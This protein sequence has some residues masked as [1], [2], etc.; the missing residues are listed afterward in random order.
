M[1]RTYG[2]SDFTA[3]NCSTNVSCLWHGFVPI[4]GNVELALAPEEQNIYRREKAVDEF[5]SGTL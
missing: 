2:T 1:F 3:G 5:V 4:I